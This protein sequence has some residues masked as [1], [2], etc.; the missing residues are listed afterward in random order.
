MATRWATSPSTATAGIELSQQGIQIHYVVDMAEIPTVQEK[1]MLDRSDDGKVS[2]TER[3]SYLNTRTGKLQRELRLTLDGVEAPLRVISTDLD[4]LPGQ[5]GLETTRLAIV[6]EADA[7]LERGRPNISRLRRWELRAEE[8]LGEVVVVAREGVQLIH[9][10]APDTDLSNQLRDYPPELAGSVPEVRVAGATFAVTGAPAVPRC[11]GRSCFGCGRSRVDGPAIAPCRGR[12]GRGHRAAVRGGSH[13]EPAGR[14]SGP[15]GTLVALLLAGVWGAAH[16]FSPG[17]WQGRRRGLPGRGARHR[18]PR[19]LPGVDGHGH[20]Y[21]G[22]VR[23][24]AAEP[25]L[26]RSSCFRR[27]STHGSRW[28]PASRWCSSV[29]ACC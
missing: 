17:A 13:S 19:R 3:A 23:A 4:F 15:F 14:N 20:P 29:R 18:S 25:S 22:R 5:A 6:F 27:R 24:R 1:A 12:D 2:E 11:V 7:S 21:A 28:S 8:G 26:P 10:T 9:S 16:A